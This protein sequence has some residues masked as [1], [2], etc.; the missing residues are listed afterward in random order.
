MPLSV[1]KLRQAPF[2]WAPTAFFLPLC[3]CCSPCAGR[4]K[5]TRDNNPMDNNILFRCVFVGLLLFV[6]SA[7]PWADGFAVDK[8]YHPYVE[9]MEQEIEWRVVAHSG[10]SASE[11]RSQL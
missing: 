9:A 11:P 4:K 6:V 1:M 2:R 10:E 7:T 3:W 8:V 5:T